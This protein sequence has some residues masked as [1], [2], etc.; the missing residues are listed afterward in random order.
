MLFHT[1]PTNAP[2]WGGSNFSSVG[3]GCSDPISKAKLDQKFPNPSAL[4]LIYTWPPA[5]AN[6]FTRSTGI[7]KINKGVIVLRL[8]F[9]SITHRFRLQGLQALTIE[10]FNALIYRRETRH[11]ECS[12]NLKLGCIQTCFI[13]SKSTARY[14]TQFLDLSCLQFM[15]GLWGFFLSKNH[16]EGELSFVYW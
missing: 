14:S 12:S 10:P 13:S 1:H 11:Q 15:G 5:N 2:F 3:G 6:P 8:L 9:T 16:I 4:L 7:R